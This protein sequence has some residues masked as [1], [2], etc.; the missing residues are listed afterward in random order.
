MGEYGENPDPEEE[1]NEI[2][3]AEQIYFQER[4]QK[5][6]ERLISDVVSY[7]PERRVPDSVYVRMYKEG[8]NLSFEIN[9]DIQKKKGILTRYLPGRFGK[10]GIQP[11]CNFEDIQI[12]KIWKNFISY[13][14][15]R[16][17]Q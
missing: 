5:D 8:K 7:T 14:K 17:N 4:V 12:G 15:K 1:K 9:K 2:E 11:L 13:A 6:L 16:T 10:Y 3:S